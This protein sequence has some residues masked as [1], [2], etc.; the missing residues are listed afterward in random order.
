MVFD[1]CR[2]CGCRFSVSSK[3]ATKEFTDYG[4]SSFCSKGCLQRFI[5]TTPITDYARVWSGGCLLGDDRVITD[6]TFSVSTLTGEG[7]RSEF[8]RGV[9]DWLHL[10]GETY[11]VEPVT[12]EVGETAHLTPDFYLPDRDIVCEVKGVWSV[13]GKA[14]F[15]RFVEEWKDQFT[16]IL[17]P[18]RLSGEFRRE[19]E[20]EWD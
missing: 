18:W 6:Q 10:M 16:I 14:K 12:F 19:E 4:I 8:E 5:Q 17:I 20:D 11:Q 9:A 7:F 13:G 2:V 15:R 3:D 1:V